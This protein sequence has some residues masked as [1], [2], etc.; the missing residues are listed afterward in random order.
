MP[1]SLNLEGHVPMRKIVHD[2]NGCLVRTV[3]SAVSNTSQDISRLIT[4]L[5]LLAANELRKNMI[6]FSS[7]ILV[8]AIN[9]DFENVFDDL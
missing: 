2:L 9:V 5:T 1:T 4:E 8:Q 6:S 3:S 7:I